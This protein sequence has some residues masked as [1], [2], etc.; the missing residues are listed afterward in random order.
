MAIS[1][2]LAL[3][4]LGFGWLVASTAGADT[5][6]LSAVQ[7]ATLFQ[8]DAELANGAGEYFFVGNT[9]DA[10]SR[11]GLL[12]FDVAASIPAGSTITNVTLDLY[13][14]RTRTGDET[15][16]LHRVLSDWG[17]GTSQAS[18]EEGAGASATDGDATW[19]YT[20][21]DSAN[22]SGSPAWSSAGGDFD[23]LVSGSA[24]V[25]NQ[26]GFYSWSSGGMVADVQDWLDGTAPDYGWL[27]LG[28]ETDTR[29]AKR[30]SSRSDSD[31]NQRPELVVDFVPPDVTGA[32]C[33]IDGSCSV[34]LD[35]GSSCGGTYQGANTSCSPNPCPQPT[36]ACCLPTATGSC[37]ED[38]ATAC[39]AQ[40]GTFQGDFSTC[41]ASSCPVVLTPF[42]DPLPRPAVAQ[43][44]SGTS[45]GAATYDLAMRETQQQLH[46]ELANPTTVWG[47]DDGGG[48]GFPGPTVEAS[49]GNPVTV[50]W[51]NDLRDTS[52]PG[53]PL[54]IQHYLPVD[55]CPHGASQNQDARTVV[56]LHGAHV[57]A[58]FDGYPEA[59]FPPGQQTTY[60]YPN[61]QLPATL[62]YHDHA[63]GITRLNVYMGLAGFWLLRDSFETSLGLPSGE[64]EIPLAIQDRTFKP[65]GSLSYPAAWQDTFFGDSVMVN[66]KV[67]PYLDVKQGKYRFRLLNGSSS[68]T[69]Q[70]SL[71][72]GASFQVLGMEGGLLPAPVPLSLVTLGPGERADVVV[73]FQNETPGTQVV[74]QNSAPSPFPGTPG[75]G[76]IP[77]V[78][79]FRVQAQAGHT[80]PVPAALRPME[81]LDEADATQFR[82]FHLEKA[83]VTG[84]S[85]TEW[86][87]RSIGAGGQVLG[88]KWDDI[89]EL[90]ELGETEV[91]K[92][93]NRS[94]MTHPMHMHL[95]MFQ[96]LDRQAYD[97]SSGAIVPIGSPV[98][99]PA[100]E[101]GW[102]D[103]V[104]VGPNEIVRV[105][106]RFENY[107]GLFSY[108]CH[109]LEHED[110]EMMRQF[111]AVATVPHCQNG[112]DD[113]GDGLVD[114]AGNDPG[115][116]G[117]ADP[118]EHSPTL[119]CDDAID[120]DG[121]GLWDAEDPA[122]ANPSTPRERSQCQDGLD[123]D[124][125]PG[126]D[127]D[128]GES[129]LGVG[130]G[131]PNGADPHCVSF[132]DNQEA[133]PSGGGY[134]CGLGPEIAL[135]L[136]LLLGVRRR[137]A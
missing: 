117:P 111:E 108:H 40:G 105:I 79:Q 60:S 54:R 94:G 20:F 71:S 53:S 68:R 16:T 46:A 125:A 37:L 80:A 15:V 57:E 9:K 128:G 29:V 123:N 73:D 30:F 5:V 78:M 28:N 92:W 48:T 135:V 96:V 137:R 77:N 1:Q 56:H 109:I 101:A 113:D 131:D 42:L 47:W 55:T 89:S 84:C 112:I 85:T 41:A 69:Y 115:C 38:T 13:M 129:I 19:L 103:T 91:W 8:E 26:N 104:Q 66:G 119:V 76:V 136:G 70:L 59:T 82:E 110:H 124:G 17:E 18:G 122:C 21:Y 45:G 98:P 106:A 65:D 121:D 63:L 114:A 11:R 86:L 126:T 90:P 10:F 83:S 116:D 107:E 22:P 61:W 31:A 39:T 67:W 3:L 25:G 6:A 97:D 132:A 102:K 49:V 118:S 100:H 4:T 120:N 35:P 99:P 34:T 27:V 74:L 75:V 36:G 72:N 93:V 32:C 88:E 51:I 43:P 127:F 134:S 50:N 2:R 7:D 133:A 14:S 23:A 62:W 12:A 44:V 64:F 87:I 81:V 52:Q 58:A 130:N 95:V 33:A 24:T